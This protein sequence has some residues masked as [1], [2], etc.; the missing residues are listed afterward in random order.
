MQEVKGNTALPLNVQGIFGANR[1]LLIWFGTLLIG[2]TLIPETLWT[3]LLVG[4]AVLAALWIL[5]RV[6]KSPFFGLEDAN[7]SVN[8]VAVAGIFLLSFIAEYGLGTFFEAF[9]PQQIEA[10]WLSGTPSSKEFV[11]ALLTTGLITPFYEE[12]IFRW[13]TLRAFASV[14]SPLFAALFSTLLFALA[15]GSFVYAAIVFPVGFMLALFVLKTRQLWSAVLVHVLSNV[16]ALFVAQ[17]ATGDYAQVAVTPLEGVVGL[18]AA[19]IALLL[20]VWWLG[21]P[22]SRADTR[23]RLWSGSLIAFIAICLALSV[24]VT[25]ST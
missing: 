5:A 2:Y 12:Y 21:F 7:R 15:H 13:V 25:V 8:L 6:S 3:D 17:F 20:A 18:C 11:L 19:L 1:I 14:R 10:V 24:I 9:F 16:Y 22:S 4:I 23:G